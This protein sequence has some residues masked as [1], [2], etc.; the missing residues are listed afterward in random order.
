MFY[1][2]AF[3]E[4]S[5]GC[6][7]NSL[8][9]QCMVHLRQYYLYEL[10]NFFKG[11]SPIETAYFDGLYV[12]Y[13]HFGFN[14]KHLVINGNAYFERKIYHMFNSVLCASTKNI[15]VCMHV[16]DIDGH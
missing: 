14:T 7:Q 13:V 2:K 15:V 10:F 5:Y 9:H 4:N 11:F 1:Q 8:K 16:V 6:E 3:N 12:F